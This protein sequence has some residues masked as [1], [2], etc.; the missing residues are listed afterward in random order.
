[1]KF[2]I[3]P[4]FEEHSSI[5]ERKIGT[6]LKRTT[7][8]SDDRL[9]IEI[10]LGASENQEQIIGKLLREFYWTESGEFLVFMETFEWPV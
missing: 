4:E 10:M 6:I 5:I 3:K 9:E 1:M 8:A 2:K 7:A